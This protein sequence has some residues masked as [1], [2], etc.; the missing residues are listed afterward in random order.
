M[1]LAIVLIIVTPVRPGLLDILLT[2]SIAI[3]MVI[4]LTTM[5]TTHTL[6]F[7]VFPSLLLVVT[8]YRLSLNIASTRLILGEASAGKI[9]S[10]FGDFVVGGNYVVGMIIFIIITVVQFVVITSGASRV[11]EVAARFTLDA[12]PGKQMSVDADLNA[13]IITEQEAKIRREELQ[14]EADF[15][16]AMDGASKFVKGDAIAGIIIT[17]INIF[18]GFVIGI[19]QLD[20]SLSDALQTYTILSVGDGLVAQIP[21]LLVSTGTGILVTRAGTG[22]SLGKD[23]VSQLTGFP[24]VV[25]LASASLFLV[26]LVPGI[27]TMPFLILSIV[28]GTLAY[29][30]FKQVGY[31]AQEEERA[32]IMERKSKERK[33][34][35]VL[36]MISLDPLEIEIGY[37]LV[38]LTDG[39]QGG[40]LLDRLAEVRRRCASELGIYV[41]PI[42]IR[43]NLEI[44]RNS[45]VFKIRGVEIEKGEIIPDRY[46]AMNPMEH[47]FPVDGIATTEPTFGLPAWWITEEN[48]EELEFKGFTV[49]D[50]ATVLVTQLTEFIKKHA[51]ELLGRQETKELVE[52]VKENNPAV[53]EELIPDL[54]SYGQVQKV[55]QNLLREQIPIKDLVT[56]LEA[57]ADNAPATQDIDFLTESVRQ[58]FFRIISNKFSVDGKLK[59]IVLDTGVEDLVGGSLQKTQQGAYPAMDPAVAEKLLHVVGDHAQGFLERGEQ[60]VVLCSPKIRLPFKR[61]LER[62]L[63]QVAV[64]SFNELAPE[65]EIEAAG[66]VSLDEN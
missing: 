18:G 65:L 8:L 9:I 58:A 3:S 37:N 36:S 16:G 54:L 31:L 13:G 25:A 50:A 64:V 60:P 23:V 61:F 15:F 29:F 47:D 45:Y 66:T 43:D 34:E 17:L 32:K 1:V 57:L 27:P 56:I 26:G 55:L 12:M 19:W 11:A 4:L 40:D 10:A 49:V 33:P 42:R 48:K 52:T 5:F 59:V 63:P 41:R 6:Q 62:F 20:M 22:E 2:I 21:A 38:S 44:D 24:K 46:M 30:L 28:T 51:H 53:V 7:S 35:D 39:E 14:Q